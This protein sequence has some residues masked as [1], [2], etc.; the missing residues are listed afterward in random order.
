MKLF[1][2]ALLAEFAAHGAAVLAI[3]LLVVVSTQVI[4]VLRIATSSLIPVEGVFALVGFALLTSLP[5]VMG[6]SLFVAVLL[7]LIRC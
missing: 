6:G 5:V 1:R 3:L 2:R 7:T 4:R